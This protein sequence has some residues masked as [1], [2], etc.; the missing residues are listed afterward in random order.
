MNSIRIEVG[1]APT[2]P[3][4]EMP[5]DDTLGVKKAEYH[6]PSL[7]LLAHIILERPR[8]LDSSSRGDLIQLS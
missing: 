4:G 2:L 8:E 5:P 3:K 7:M 6:K 1:H